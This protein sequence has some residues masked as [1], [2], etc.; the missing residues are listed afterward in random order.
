M[1]YTNLNVEK[2]GHTALITIANPPANTWT[3]DSLQALK[4]LVAD[5]NAAYRELPALHARDCEPEGFNWLI[6]NDQTNSVF[7]WSRQAPGSDPVVVVANLTPVPRENYRVP[8]PKAEFDA[9]IGFTAETRLSGVDI[10][11]RRLRK[12][13][14]DAVLKFAGLT[15]RDAPAE[16]RRA[17][18]QVAVAGTELAQHP[19]RMRAFEDAVVAG[20]GHVEVVLADRQ[21]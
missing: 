20:V 9:V 16:F 19:A 4:R 3:Y 21:A 8:M 2:I 5:L 1:H 15:E 13:A 6:A 14:V 10:G 12:G 11:Q 17:V 18:D 7:A